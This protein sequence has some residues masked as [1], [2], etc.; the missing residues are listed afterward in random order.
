VHLD[1]TTKGFVCRGQIRSRVWVEYIDYLA[2]HSGRM[3]H[4]LVFERP[5]R[6]YQSQGGDED[7]YDTGL[8]R[9]QVNC[10][11]PHYGRNVGHC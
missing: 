2:I 1:F 9:T 7:E 4:I 11:S 10:L 3:S 5:F 6:V 8:L